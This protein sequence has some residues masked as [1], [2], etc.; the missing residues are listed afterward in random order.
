MA[1][2][3][4]AFGMI[5]LGGGYTGIYSVGI[6]KA[7][8]ELGM[9]PKIVT[10]SSVSAL[11]VPFAIQHNWESTRPLEIVFDYVEKKG[12]RFV[13]NFGFLEILTALILRKDHISPNDGVR[14][15]VSHLDSEKIVG[16]DIELRVI[17][18]NEAT[19]D[20]ETFSTRDPRIIENPEILKDI[21]I[22]SCGFPGILPSHKVNGV[23]YHDAINPDIISDI[24]DLFESGCERVY[25]LVNSSPDYKKPVKVWFL[26]K[27]MGEVYRWANSDLSAAQKAYGK[28]LVILR[29]PEKVEHLSRTSFK[30]GDFEKALRVAYVSSKRIFENLK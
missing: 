20:E 15:L 18:V 29:P 13:F 9:R 4:E 26:T 5:A 23:L 3:A 1:D 22:A 8:I 12:P 16:S 21:I 14:E 11:N 10:T 24:R 19:N 6:M 30:K 7:M 17:A 28:R 2:P 27:I 25:L